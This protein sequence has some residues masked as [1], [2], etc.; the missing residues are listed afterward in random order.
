[1]V[2]LVIA[3]KPKS[4]ARI[5]SALDLK[6]KRYKRITYFSG[7]VNGEQVYVVPALGHL[8]TLEQKGK[9]FTYPV[10]EVQWV[11]LARAKDFCELIKKVGEKAN[12]AVNACDFDIEGSLI[13]YNAI[14]F[15][16]RVKE[17]RRMKFSSLTREELRKAFENLN[18]LDLSHVEAGIARHTIDWF[19]G[20]NLSRALMLSLRKVGKWRVLS[21]GRVQGPTLALL[22]KRELEIKNFKPK[23]FFLLKA[24]I[25]GHDFVSKVRFEREEEARQVRD[26]ISA[27]K[28]SLLEK[29]VREYKRHIPPFDLTTLQVEAYRIY[30]LSPSKTLRI[31][32]SLYENALISYP[33]TSSQKLPRMNFRRIITNLSKLSQYK[34]ACEEI[35]KK[36]KLVPFQGKKEDPA[37][38]AIHPTGVI[39][40]ELSEDQRKVYDLIVRRFLA[41]FS[42]PLVVQ[43]Y[44]LKFSIGGYVFE[45]EFSN[46]SELG[47]LKIYSFMETKKF[48]DVFDRES[49]EAEV[50]V[51]K[52]KEKGPRRYTQASLLRE[53]EKR[54]LGTKGTRAQ[55]IATLYKRGYIAGKRIRV[56]DL[57]F[58]VYNLLKCFSPKI[59]SEELT[60]ELER[61]LEDIIE[62]KKSKDEVVDKAKK[63]LEQILSEMKEKESQLARMLSGDFDGASSPSGP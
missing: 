40:E 63:L 27:E 52:V 20:I 58:R 16:T 12:V 48:K 6:P 1:M 43:R 39:P 9:A 26:K 7:E 47:W 57:G 61:D 53:M 29:E 4:A 44:N 23:I 2:M 13:G 55:I 3:E 34:D 11:P 5:A 46:Y 15:L 51:E 14:R 56:K 25:L 45:G 54:G 35:L 18:E 60:R 36:K 38:P 37:H 24:R 33:R 62:G 10:F 32:Q 42:E 17:I 21:I 31:A 41:C 8:F 19:W 59:L 50:K 22:V 49:Y 30:G 28:A